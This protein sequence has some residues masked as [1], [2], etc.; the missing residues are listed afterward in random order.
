MKPSATGRILIWRGGSLWIGLAG[1]PAGLHAH[2]AVQL[3]LPFAHGSVRFQV[4]GGEWRSYD[5]AIVAA[6]Q[7]HAFDARGQHMATIFVDP[8]SRDGARLQ[9]RYRPEGVAALDTQLL[10]D[11]ITSLSEAYERQASDQVLT[12]LTHSVIACVAG[13]SAVA[14][15]PTDPR[16]A[17]AMDLIRARLNESISLT[18]LASAVK[19]SPDRLRHLFAEQTGVGLRPYVLW[20]RLETSLAAYVAGSTLTDAAY[21]G[22]FADSAHFSRTFKKMFGISPAS[23][24]PE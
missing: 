13:S 11:E 18:S 21:A 16:V 10:S 15:N 6:E 23:V 1:A 24:R 8:E 2:H 19:L 3:A 7:P 17:L 20:L 5:A 14:G 4:P 12:E 22:G 9:A